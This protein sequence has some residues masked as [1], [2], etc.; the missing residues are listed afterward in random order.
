MNKMTNENLKTNEVSIESENCISVK[1]PTGKQMHANHRRRMR[2]K[3][4]KYGFEALSDH[5]KLELLLFYAIPRANTNE[6]GHRLLEKFGSFS[7]VL[8]APVDEIIAVDGVG[9]RSA[10]FL[11]IIPQ[12]CNYYIN[13][14]CIKFN[15][16]ET[17]DDIGRYMKNKFIGIEVE[18]VYMMCFDSRNK[19]IY[20]SW[21]DSLGTSTSVEL[22]SQFIVKAAIKCSATSVAIGHNHPRGV[23]V[24][25][26]ADLDAT[27]GLTDTLRTIKVRLI[28]HFVFDE[29]GYGTL[30]NQ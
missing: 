4:E 8:D 19:C 7:A 1:K 17:I 6:Q 9:E 16:F 5:E 22:N 12:I 27:Y 3:V 13:D 20:E 11:K 18:K 30:I 14:K 2:E 29:N 28:E 10:S 26:S 24:P 15:T 23:S 25:S 21:V